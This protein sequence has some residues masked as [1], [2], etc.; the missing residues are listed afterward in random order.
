M[1]VR[2][3]RK[4]VSWLDSQ[5]EYLNFWKLVADGRTW[6]ASERVLTFDDGWEHVSPLSVRCAHTGMH[7]DE[8][9]ELYR[10]I[11]TAVHAEELAA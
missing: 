1:S 8:S 7:L 4:S 2:V 3:I 5:R 11:L 10:D 6:F 9:S